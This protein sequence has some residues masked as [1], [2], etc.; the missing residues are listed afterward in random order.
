[1]QE[2]SNSCQT[3]RRPRGMR[4]FRHT[5]DRKTN[6]QE[7][8]EWTQLKNDDECNQTP[9]RMEMNSRFVSAVQSAAQVLTPR[10]SGSC[11]ER[12]FTS[13]CL[14]FLWNVLKVKT[15]LLFKQ[16]MRTRRTRPWF[17][18]WGML[19]EVMKL[20]SSTQGGLCCYLKQRGTNQQLCAHEMETSLGVRKKCRIQQLG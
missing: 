8:F 3:T 17:P 15:F 11:L 12:Q 18:E 2:L 19:E 5:C 14:N 9:Y 7:F 20:D 1:M 16:T 6:L 13:F 4:L 10:T